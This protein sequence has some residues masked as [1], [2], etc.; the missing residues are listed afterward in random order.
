MSEILFLSLAALVVLNVPIAVSIGFATF[1][2]IAVSGKAPLFLVAQRMF[3][4]MDSFPLLAIP[5]FMVAGVLM[6]RGGISKRLIMLATS[7][8][9]NVH[10]GLGII[11]I[12]ACMFFAAISGS[13]PATVVAIGSIMVPAMIRAGYARAFSLAILAAAGTIGV[14]IPPSIP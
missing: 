6:D 2:A 8:V 9:G 4:G 3:T 13:A 7:L 14:V 11:A 5:L 1:L 12:L 10:G